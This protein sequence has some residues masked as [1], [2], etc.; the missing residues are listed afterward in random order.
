[1]IS[2][3]V[4]EMEAVRVAE[5]AAEFGVNPATIR[6]DLDELEQQG[7]L[8]R[9]HGG[10]VAP[11][12]G[13]GTAS[14]MAEDG[15]PARIGRA[16]AEM[17]ADGETVYIGSGRLCLATAR[18]L[19]IR[20]QLT[21]VTN[22]LEVAHWLA[23]STS[24][25]LIVTGGQADGGR[26]GLGGQLGLQALSSVRADQVV[27]QF[28]GVSALGGLTVDTLQQADM[29]RAILDTGSCLIALV[30]PERVGRVAAAHVAP[31]SEADAV[32]TLRE[33]PSS[34]LWDLSECG[35]RIVLA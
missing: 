17:I 1:V 8:R 19:T 33:A 26:L 14:Q 24:H 18:C 5:L 4:A 20:Q 16:V 11:G 21:I 22:G 2:R 12:S 28:D 34:F 10:A 35:V 25:S 15:W 13:G 29:A 6:R 9:V 31:V 27:L 32:V 3:M 30:E 23:V 7:K